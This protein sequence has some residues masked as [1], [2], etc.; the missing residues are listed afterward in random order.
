MVCAGIYPEGKKDTCQVSDGGN[1][2]GL[3]N[4]DRNHRILL[5]LYIINIMHGLIRLRKTLNYPDS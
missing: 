1:M 2:H 4:T 3:R 5:E